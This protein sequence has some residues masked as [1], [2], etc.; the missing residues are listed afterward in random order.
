[1]GLWDHEGVKF[2]KTGTEL[3]RAIR[4]RSRELE[5][6]LAERDR[7]L[8]QIMSDRRLLRSFLVRETDNDYPHRSQIKQDLPSEEHHRVSELCKRI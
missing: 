2:H 4:M 7:Q 3:K 1:M 8:E 5:R 6:R